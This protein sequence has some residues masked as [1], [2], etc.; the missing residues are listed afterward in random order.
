MSQKRK[1][2]K[3]NIVF[4]FALWLILLFSSLTVLSAA[5]TPFLRNL[6]TQ[7]VVSLD[8]AGYAAASSLIIQQP[9]VVG[10][11][12]SWTVPTVSVSTFD[13]YSAAWVGIG[14]QFDATL[15][16]VGTEHDSLNGQE[17]YSVW[18]EMLPD[19]SVT[20]ENV[21]IKPGD[22]IAAAISLLDSDA[23][24]WLIEID[25]L[26]NG[27]SFHQTFIY[28]STRLSAEWVVERPTVNNEITTLA[29]FGNVIFTEAS[30]QVGT[31]T[32]TIKSFPNYEIVMNNRQNTQLVEIS[33]L[34]ADGTSFSV[35]YSR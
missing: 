35:T 21:S 8:W 20:I 17:S 32:G 14:G 23:N 11:N 12:G 25:N 9:I 34:S 7:S 26:S 3:I 5:V 15:I 19:E 22:R 31:T 10:V 1:N 27:Q 16:Q 2:W 24:S 6:Q 18:Y 13:A 33:T 29:D 4:I 28:N 30:A